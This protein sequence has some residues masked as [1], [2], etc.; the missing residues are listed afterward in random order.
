MTLSSILLSNIQV[1]PSVEAIFQNFAGGLILAVVAAELFP[2]MLEGTV[3]NSMVG[4]TIG[5]IFA[6]CLLNGLEVFIEYLEE[7][8]GGDG[9][10]GKSESGDSE[11]SEIGITHF[12]SLPSGFETMS[13]N[14]S[15]RTAELTKGNVKVKSKDSEDAEE[16]S[17]KK[18]KKEGFKST[19]FVDWEPESVTVAAKAFES[20]NHR[21]HIL[22]HMKEMSTAI[23]MMEE[24]ANKLIEGKF[25]Y[26]F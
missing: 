14:A 13:E 23:R 18:D 24:R 6:L 2:L 7:T 11:H 5:F 8:I 22:D 15:I 4:V 3:V 26:Y 10:E 12:Q 9:E 21:E 1:S 17:A 25:L 16:K 19:C 20:K